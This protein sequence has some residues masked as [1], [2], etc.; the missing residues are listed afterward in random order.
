MSRSEITLAEV[1]ERCRDMEETLLIELLGLS[2]STI[3]DRCI[4]IIE[5]N[6]EFLISELEEL[7]N[8]DEYAE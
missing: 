7:S 6:I 8:E 5:D 2:S 4:D 3:V 1:I